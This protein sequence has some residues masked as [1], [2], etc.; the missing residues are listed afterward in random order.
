MIT[1]DQGKAE[2]IEMYFSIINK[3][4]SEDT[5]APVIDT[6]LQLLGNLLINLEHRMEAIRGD[7]RK[8]CHLLGY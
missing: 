3:V 8:Q 6:S 5:G 7:E 1:H 4:D 2:S